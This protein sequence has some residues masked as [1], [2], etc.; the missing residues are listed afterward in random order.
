MK[1]PTHLY[2]NLYIGLLGH[3]GVGKTRAISAGRKLYSTLPEFHLAPISMTFASLVDQLTLAKRYIIQPPEE[4]IHYNSL[5]ICADELGA[6]ISKYDNEMTDG[7]SAFYNVTPYGQTRRTKELKIQI[8]RPQINLLFGST[9]QNLTELMPEK[10]WGQGFTSR[11]IM[12]FS[13]ERII[14]DDFAPIK[15]NNTEDLKTDLAQMN[16]LMGEFHVT[17]DFGKAVLKWKHE[18]EPPLPSHPR[19]L[20]YNAR[21]RENLYKLAMISAI[22]K[23]NGLVVTLE[24]FNQAL[25]WL[26][27]AEHWMSDIFKAG[28]T[29]ADAQAMDEIVYF[30]KINQRENGVSAQKIINFARERI[31]IHSILRIIEILE[32]TGQITCVGEDRVTKI[33]YYKASAS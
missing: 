12:I 16:D 15:V 22:D 27:E 25:M 14:T 2:C 23:S 18:G 1:S 10:A 5:Y 29:N 20:H 30:V 9:P 4:P 32:Q 24:D 26:I 13:D 7:L 33:R 28:A 31:P 6:F 11:L 21:R 19:L 17:E 8:E 3:P